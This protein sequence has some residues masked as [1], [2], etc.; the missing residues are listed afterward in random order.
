M[1]IYKQLFWI[2]LFSYLG[3]V[4]SHFIG[5]LIPGN[6]IGLLLLFMALHFRV[7]EMGQVEAVGNFLKDNLAILFVPAGVAI[8]TYFDVIRDSWWMLLIIVVVSTLLTLLFT[9]RM[10]QS[11]I[12]KDRAT[13]EA[14]PEEELLQE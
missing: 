14:T 10:V 2:L 4:L 12:Q 3:E 8:M 9:A 11:M 6:V 1:K 13:G 7:L 5:K